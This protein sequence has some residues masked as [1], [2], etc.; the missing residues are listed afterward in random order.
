VATLYGN[1]PVQADTGA[2]A[3]AHLAKV[4]LWASA[5]KAR[6]TAPEQIEQARR[7]EADVLSVMPAP[8]KAEL[9]S[10]VAEHLS[11]FASSR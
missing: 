11:R 3:P 2:L 1:A 9:D 8:W 6:L 7:I 5:A 10:K 4:Y